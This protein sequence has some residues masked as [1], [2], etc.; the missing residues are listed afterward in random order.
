[1]RG[2][3][4]VVVAAILGLV[5]GAATVAV[6][7]GVHHGQNL[8]ASPNSSLAAHAG[9]VSAVA[10]AASDFND[11]S[12]SST[13]LSLVPGMKTTISVP[14]GRRALLDIRFSA[15]TAC[16]GGT[17]SDWC[18]AE[19]LVDGVEASPGD[20]RDYALDSTDNSTETGASWEGHAMERVIVVGP[21]RHV[22]KVIGGVTDFNATG[23]QTFWTGE[24]TLVVDRSLI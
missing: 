18:I 21:G 14:A 10:V 6:A 22:V 23:S 1:M 16:Y 13:T 9:A 20:G 2:R 19:I 4:L 7:A 5:V 17:S 3:R 24:R 11:I 12:N 8:G 15:E